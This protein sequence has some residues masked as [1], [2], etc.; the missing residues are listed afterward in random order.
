MYNSSLEVIPDLN[1]TARVYHQPVSE[2]SVSHGL[3]IQQ[4]QFFLVSLSLVQ[5]P[6]LLHM[7]LVSRV[8]TYLGGASSYSRKS[9]EGVTKGLLLECLFI[10]ICCEYEDAAKKYW[11]GKANVVFGSVGRAEPFPGHFVKSTGTGLTTLEAL[12]SRTVSLFLMIFWT[13]SPVKLPWNTIHSPVLPVLPVLPI[14]SASLPYLYPSLSY[15]SSYLCYR[16]HLHRCT[17][18]DNR[19]IGG[20][21]A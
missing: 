17:G 20:T 1:V 2:M 8:P 6:A 5:S 10:A 16:P 18:F 11:T 12:F 13:R 4:N 19:M 3:D 15:Y 7:L 21:C 14:C 9:L